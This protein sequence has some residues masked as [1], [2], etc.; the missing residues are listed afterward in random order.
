MTDTERVKE[1][2]KRDKIFL[3]GAGDHAK[4]VLSTLEE[5]GFQCVGIY[6]DN[7]GL[8]GKTLWC[9]PILG[10]VSEMPDTEETMA[11]I[12]IG[13]NRIRRA[14]RERFKN[15]CWPALLH[16]KGIVDSSVRIGE[17]TIIMAGCIIESDTIIGR[18]SIINSGC[19]L[20]HDTKVGDYC[21]AAP[22][23]ATGNSVTLED[24]VL[25][26]MGSLVRPYTTIARDV[27][28]GMGSIVV[29]DIG[30]GGTWA[31]SPAKLIPTPVDD[32]R[33]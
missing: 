27:T 32:G 31:G 20:G 4:V 22:K 1:M 26:G 23:S 21:H 13:D 16:P 3:I 8:R 6:D 29:K 9:L 24:G 5:C 33:L 25:L 14:I 11:V 18:Q 10:P 30:P 2:E 15:V 19:L 7:A 28:V 17:G 12:A